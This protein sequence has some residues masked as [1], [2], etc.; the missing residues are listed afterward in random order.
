L[1]DYIRT[2]NLFSDSASFIRNQGTS[3]STPSQIYLGENLNA[4][5]KFMVKATSGPTWK[6]SFLSGQQIANFLGQGFGLGSIGTAYQ[7]NL[8]AG[9]TQFG[10]WLGKGMVLRVAGLDNDADARLF[11][12]ASVSQMK[13]PGLMGLKSALCSINSIIYGDLLAPELAKAAADPPDPHFTEVFQ[14][15]VASTAPFSFSGV[16]PELNRLL[17]LEIGSLYNTYYLMNGM[18][19]SINRYGSALEA[20]DAVSAGLQFA[21]F[22]K[23]LTLYDTAAIQ[24]ADYLKQVRQGL[25]SEG[26]V[27]SGYNQQDLLALQSLLRQSGLPQEVID[28]YKSL[29]LTDGEIADLIQKMIDFVPPDSLSGTLYSN[30]SDGSNLLLSVSSAPVPIPGAV[31]LFGSGLLGLVGWRRFEKG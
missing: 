8:Y 2:P 10:L 26:L 7:Y 15:R 11:M 16:S 21:A 28:Y 24:A 30:L 23:Y 17:G 25:I 18:T 29:G 20:G 13:L 5:E 6:E 4:L 3:F 27:D 31:W 9:F 19:N 1:N 22:V 14:S 12:D